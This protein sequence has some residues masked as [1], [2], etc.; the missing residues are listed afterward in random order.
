MKILNNIWNFINPNSD[1]NLDT[2][3]E[4]YKKHV[5]YYKRFTSELE[6]LEYSITHASKENKK[7]LKIE[8]KNILSEIYEEL[9]YEAKKDIY[10][11]AW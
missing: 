1:E 2:S 6:Q 4:F 11:R 8:F 9:D 10:D 7:K 3:I 5:V